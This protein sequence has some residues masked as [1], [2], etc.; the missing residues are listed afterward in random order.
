MQHPVT[1][2]EKLE[3]AYDAHGHDGHAKLLRQ[4]ENTFLE[5]LDV[6]V[7]CAR[8]LRKSNQAGSRIKRGLRLLVHPLQALA[9]G[10]VR[11]RNV[12]E[13]PHHPTVHWHLEVRFQLE[14]AQ[15]LRNRGVD[16]E[17]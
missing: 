10:W 17:G 8:A 14:A 4:A 5:G 13:A 11:H 3:G 1:G 15:E 9:A 12:P 7:A 16:D 6:A 2:S